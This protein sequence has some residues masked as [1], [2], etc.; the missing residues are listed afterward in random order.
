MRESL[1]RSFFALLAAVPI[2]MLVAPVRAPG[3]FAQRLVAAE[4]P[5]FAVMGAALAVILAYRLALHLRLNRAL[6]VT[7]TCA[8]FLLA[9][10]RPFT[11]DDPIGYLQ[12]AGATGL[13]LA[14]VLALL[15]A[16]ASYAART[17]GAIAVVAVFV[18]LFVIDISLANLFHVAL[19][20][21]GRLGDSYAA[22]IV[23]VALQTLLW[24]IGIHGPATLAAI[25]TPLYLA[26]QAQN[27]DAFVHRAPLPHI[28]VSS[29][30][31]ILYPGG[32]GATLPLPFML[33]F[34]RSK[35]L[36]VLAR[37]TIL[38]AIVN[39]NEPLLFGLPIVWDPFLVLP[40][41]LVPLLTATFTYFAVAHGLV[42]RA[43]TY[44]PGAVPAPVAA[45]LATLDW[46]AVML[47]L[48][49]IAIAA[50][51]YLPFVRA[52]EKHEAA[53]E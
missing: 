47:S 4:L 5:S 8:C 40:F 17:V 10:P 35:R 31:P 48:V 37:A 46:R 22:L 51:V 38:P 44:V 16:G 23:V 52:Y 53:A 20:P 21:L 9:L 2:F 26:L 39:I 28:V 41:I 42:A 45:Y 24:T 32:A 7:A 29:L 13:F 3:G 34:S 25:V 1:P 33:L 11:F 36:R 50:L 30:F 27:T 49:N 19:A 12:R 14:I 18:V 43:Y 15:V 6:T